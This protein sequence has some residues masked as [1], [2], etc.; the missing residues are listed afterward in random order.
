MNKR[1]L[2]ITTVPITLQA[3]LLP[4]C[5]ALQEAGWGVDALTGDTTDPAMAGDRNLL[6]SHFGTIHSIGWGRSLASLFRYPTFARQIRKLVIDGTYDVVHVHTPIAAFITRI[7]L[8]RTRCPD[9]VR[10]IYTVHGFHFL[11]DRQP[12]FSSLLYMTAERYAI[13]ATDDLVV[14]NDMDEVA[15][16]ELVALTEQSAR[17]CVLHRIDGTGLDFSE[18]NEPQDRA[19]DEIP[20]PAFMIGMIAEM[21]ENKRHALVI[22]AARRVIASH[23]DTHFIFIGTGPLKDHLKQKISRYNLNEHIHLTGQLAHPEVRALIPKCDLG[24]LASKR[25]GLP[26]S[27]ME[28]I[29][30]GIPIAGVD[31]RGII[32][33]VRNSSAL[34]EP[35]PDTLAALINH[36]IDNP[37]QL[38]SLAKQQHAHAIKHYDLAVV[39]PQYL[40]LYCK[41]S[42]RG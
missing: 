40:S 21:N 30:S 19:L 25:E 4:L 34:C 15:G 36:L 7:A 33:E 14:M 6:D 24:I 3:F 37:E 42:L 13:H 22:E 23:P 39:I 8:K 11:N 41:Q 2:F 31:T 1:A 26:R 10:V 9:K 38:R 32:D 12:S 18:Y 17:P 29:A 5:D 20:E 27:L 16:K 35:S 28:F